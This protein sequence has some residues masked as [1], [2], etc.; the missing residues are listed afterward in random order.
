[1]TTTGVARTTKLLRVSPYFPVADVERTARYYETV[2]GFNPDY[3]A[4]SPAMFAILS[5]DGQPLMLRRIDDPKAIVP[6]QKQGGAWDA[7]FW[8]SDARELHHELRASGATVLYEPIIQPYQVD[9]FA[10][11]DQDGHVLGFGQ[12]LES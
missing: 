2:L 10:V 5:R 12:K 4:G 8:V 3:M 11:R 6:M 7:F 1:M 9:E